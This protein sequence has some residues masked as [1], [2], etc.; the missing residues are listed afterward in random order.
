[1]FHPGH[2]DTGNFTR[3][4]VGLFMQGGCDQLS[5]LCRRH[6]RRSSAA[7]PTFLFRDQTWSDRA[8]ADRGRTNE[9]EHG[10]MKELE[11]RK[12]KDVYKDD[13]LPNWELVSRFTSMS[14][15]PSPYQ[16][17]SLVVDYLIHHGYSSTARAFAH[18]S[19]LPTSL[20][21][22]GDEIMQPADA[23]ESTGVSRIS[24]ETFLQIELRQSLSCIF[25]RMYAHTKSRNQNPY[26]HRSR[27]RCNRAPRATLPRRSVLGAPSFRP[28][29]L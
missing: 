2:S 14:R 12:A 27:R 8:W 25:P 22:D 20:D 16:L 24:E 10:L 6:R 23:T 7:S 19:M 9:Q 5:E 28:H 17:R 15:E 3:R 18:G 11:K 1:M 4:V 29:T 21:A 13:H 26:P